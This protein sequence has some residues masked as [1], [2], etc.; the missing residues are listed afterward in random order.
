MERA[1]QRGAVAELRV[2]D[3]ARVRLTPHL[4]VLGEA[5]KQPRKESGSGR[6]RGA[7]SPGCATASCKGTSVWSCPWCKGVVKVTFPIMQVAVDE[8]LSGV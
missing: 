5:A 2:A 7:V 8:L 1:A 6:F 3:R 4:T